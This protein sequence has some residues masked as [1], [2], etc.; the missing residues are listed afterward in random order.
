MPSFHIK[1]KN[2]KQTKTKQTI[3]PT[4]EWAK[5][6]YEN[7]AKAVENILWYCTQ[8]LIGEVKRM[9]ND[10]MLKDRMHWTILQSKAQDLDFAARKK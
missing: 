7:G 9:E 6:N 4:V 5:N 1:K 8:K 2:N 3:K 10:F